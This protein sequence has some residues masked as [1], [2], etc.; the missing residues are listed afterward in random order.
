[1]KGNSEQLCLKIE[2]KSEVW[3]IEI[4]KLKFKFWFVTLPSPALTYLL[5]IFIY[6]PCK[7]SL[8]VVSLHH[9]ISS[10]RST[11][12]HTYMVIKSIKSIIKSTYLCAKRYYLMSHSFCAKLFFKRCN[13]IPRFLCFKEYS[14]ILNKPTF[15]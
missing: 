1:M 11:C 3:P 6:L 5:K 2:R 10:P 7:A 9:P 14:S 15:Y 8:P 13:D 12:V 4:S